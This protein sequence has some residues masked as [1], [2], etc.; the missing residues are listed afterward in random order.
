MP[1]RPVPAH[2]PTPNAVRRLIKALAEAYPEALCALHHASPFQLLAATILSAQCTDER[3]NMV[4]PALFERYPDAPSLAAAK[5]DDVEQIIR[6]TGF[7]HAKALN[8]IGMAQAVVKN[9]GGELPRTLEELIQLPGVGRKTA[10]VLLGTAFGI[11]SGV[12]VDTHVKRISQLLGLTT[13]TQP[14]KIE[15]DLIQLL[16]RSEWVNFSHRLIHHGRQ[17]CIARRP[18]CEI[19]PLLKLCP[20]VGLPPLKS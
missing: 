7:Y 15:Q 17:I 2:G 20:R 19:C 8:L 1:R 12:V 3:V 11:A 10:N 18:K 13:A 5:L 6:S 14:E 16:P 9:H 4:T